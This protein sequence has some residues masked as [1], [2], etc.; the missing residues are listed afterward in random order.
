MCGKLARPF[1][2]E[3][4]ASLAKMSRTS[5]P[6][7]RQPGEW[8]LSPQTHSTVRLAVVAC[9]VL[10][11]V[12]VLVIATL[13]GRRADRALDEAATH[14]LR[15]YAGYAGR[16]MGGDVLRRF[17]EQRAVILAPVTGSANRDV[18][19]PRLDDIVARGNRYFSALPGAA[20]MNLGYFRVDLRTHASQSRGAI[21]R[22]FATRIADTLARLVANVP[23][24]PEP[25]ILVLEENGAQRSVAYASLIGPHGSPTAVYGFTYSRAAAIIA[26]ASIAFRET[27]LLPIS[28]AGKRWNYDT[29]AKRAGEVVNDSLLGVRIADRAGR[30]FWQSDRVAATTG[31]PFSETVV[32]STAT[33]GIVVQVALRA[34]SESS[35]IPSVVRHSQRLSLS[36]LLALTVLLSIVSLLALRQERL[37]ARAR[38]TEAMQQLA[39]GVRH[40]INNALASVML[41]AELLTE[42]EGLDADQRERLAAIVEQADRM[43]TVLRRLEKAEHLDNVVPYMNEGYMVDLS[44]TAGS[45]PPSEQPV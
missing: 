35:L 32:M 15:D 22:E 21:T 28:F 33:G 45:A 30:V 41:N 16:T 18:A 9:T 19:E 42:E 4:L 2:P 12:V 13:E 24:I 34:S 1:L 27:P 3:G 20:D 8:S 44:A 11:S 37:G 29:T 26:V 6:L 43:R 39:L 5:T 38:R 23:S 10:V 36:A 25:N 31:T 14:T 40:E 17:S 7:R